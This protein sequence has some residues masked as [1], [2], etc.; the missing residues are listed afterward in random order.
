M[1][2][3]TTTDT[4]TSVNTSTDHGHARRYGPGFLAKLAVMALINALGLYG[5]W[6]AWAVESYTIVAVMIVGLVVID[7]IYFTPRAL[8]AK[9]LA[10]GMA[11]LLVYQLFVMGYT[12]YIAFTN[13]GSGHNTT[14]EDAISQIM[15]QNEIRTPD[16]V[17]LPAAVVEKNGTLGLAVVDADGN[18]SVGDAD[19][20]MKPA[21]G[22]TVEG[23]TIKDI[24]GWEMLGLAQLQDNQSA[25]TGLR[26]AAGEDAN[27]GA[28]KTETGSS[29]FIASS[30]YTYDKQADT[31]TNTQTGETFRDTGT[32]AFTS[33][34]GQELYPGWRVPVGLQNF[35][36]MVVGTDI[37]GPFF[38]AL[39][40]SFAFAILSVLTTFALGL[41]LAIVFNDER[42]K[43]RKIYRSL[44]ILPYAFPAFLSALVWRGMM[45]EKYGFINQV[46]L[47]GADIPWLSDGFLA[48][49]S[50]LIVNL[51]LGFPYM[52]LIC[53]GALQSLPGDVVEA[54]KIDGASALRQFW[55]ITLPLVLVST[56]PLLIASFAF[57]FNNFSLI[58]MLTGGGPNYPGISVPVGHTDILISLVYAIAFEG[59]SQRYGLAAAMSI[60]IFLMVGV[61]SWLGFRQTRKLEEMV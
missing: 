57:N 11:F 9:Y 58:Y 5:I 27:A 41:F 1:A 18:V 49:I 26:V 21:D 48:K 55:S 14:K 19:H 13:Y 23:T 46:L 17:T 40:W 7:W 3:T 52:F 12:G 44:L 4:D 47:G 25:I 53:T 33:D 31:L 35:K 38:R 56:A 54:A 32:G 29:A 6:A 2:A 59:G 45:N 8:P 24:P 61:I 42:I 16:A 10:P 22:A 39:V 20:P 30:V 51:W 34:G 15:A 43:G 50:I 36:D 37:A 28:W 60:V